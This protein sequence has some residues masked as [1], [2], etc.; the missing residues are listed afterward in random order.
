MARTLRAA[1][2]RRERALPEGREGASEERGF[3]CIG[4]LFTAAESAQRLYN[5]WPLR[6]LAGAPGETPG[7]RCKSHGTDAGQTNIIARLLHRWVIRVVRPPALPDLQTEVRETHNA[8]STLCLRLFYFCPLLA[9]PAAVNR[10]PSRG[11]R[12]PPPEIL[13]AQNQGLSPLS[14]CPQRYGGHPQVFSEQREGLSLR[15][16]VL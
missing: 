7:N 3:P 6:L 5:T 8:C 14:R 15:R 10:P 13:E 1:T 11:R 16:A 12:A 9:L 4:G 2:E